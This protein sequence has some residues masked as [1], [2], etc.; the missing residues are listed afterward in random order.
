M[1]EII[2]NLDFIKKVKLLWKTN[3]ENEKT[4]HRLGEN[5][6]KDKSD[7]GLFSKIYNELKLNNKKTSYPIKKWAKDLYKNLTKHT[8]M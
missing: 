4:N 7:K 6:F 2:D 1:K 3:Q 5:I 8:Q